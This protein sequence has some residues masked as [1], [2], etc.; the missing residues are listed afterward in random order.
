MT[1]QQAEAELS[2]RCCATGSGGWVMR[3]A[4]CFAG[5][6]AII[7]LREREALPGGESWQRRDR[8]I[9]EGGSWRTV[10]AIIEGGGHGQ[11]NQ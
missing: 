10:L 5:G 8:R 1:E 11:T 3:E 9:A 6:H 2:R 4:E 7:S